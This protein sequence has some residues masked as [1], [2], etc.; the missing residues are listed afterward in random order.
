MSFNI[1]RNSTF[2]TLS[3]NIFISLGQSPIFDQNW[4]LLWSDSFEST[5][6]APHW[7]K[8]NYAVHSDE[9]QLYLASNVYIQNG[10]LHLKSMNIPVQCPLLPP[11]STYAC[12]PCNP[13]QTY[14]YTSGWVETNQ[15]KSFKYG[16]FETEL[17]LPTGNAL[18]PAFWTWHYNPLPNN[19]VLNESEIDI[20]EAL[21]YS[22]QSNRIGT[23]LHMKYCDS[24]YP[25]INCD[26][27][28][29]LTQKC[30]SY[31]PSILCYGEDFPNFNF[32]G[33][34]K[35][36]IEWNPSTIA[37]YFDD[38]MIRNVSNPGINDSIR[39]IFNVAFQNNN[40]PNF[41]NIFPTY[42]KVNYVNYYKLKKSCLTNFYS[43]SFNNFDYRVYNEIN[44]GDPGCINMLSSNIAYFLRAIGGY[45]FE[46]VLEIPFGT[47]F[48]LKLQNCT[49]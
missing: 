46:G 43:C 2:V 14:Y 17:E 33:V 22:P 9:P 41:T 37:W 8:A 48:E 42:M 26:T 5:S 3:L 1:I 25:S 45:S 28:P 12:S 16:Y 4:E 18:W 44:I 6:L 23:N 30:P 15:L 32:S 35:F 24:N 13:L 21:F 20:F 19:Q 47:T 31:D 49:E 36:G 7:L 39:L 11:V 40:Y 34:H 10:K 29:Y 27:V 38:V